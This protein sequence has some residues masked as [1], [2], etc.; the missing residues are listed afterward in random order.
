MYNAN[1]A[2]SYAGVCEDTKIQQLVN[3]AADSTGASAVFA[4]PNTTA[5]SATVAACNDT[6]TEWAI[7]A[8]LATANSWCVDSSGV[9]TRTASYMAA[10]ATQCP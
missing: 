9:A 10:D 8:P 1:G 7:Q 4:E 3:A 2:F 5:P 6:A